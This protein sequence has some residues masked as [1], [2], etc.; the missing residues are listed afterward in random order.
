MNT[1]EVPF[2]SIDDGKIILNPWNE[3][4]S[5]VIGEVREEGAEVAIEYFVNRFSELE[6]KITELEQTIESTDNKGS[7]LQKVLHLKDSL[8][9]HDALG[10]YAALNERLVKWEVFLSDIIAK[11]R[12]RNTEIKHGLIAELREAVKIINWKESTEVVQDIKGRWIKV[13]NAVADEQ[14]TLDDTF[15]G[16]VQQYFDRKRAFQED[17]RRLEAKY[18]DEYRR[19]LRESRDIYRLE[20]KDRSERIRDLK[21]RWRENGNI[22]SFKYKNLLSKF[23]Y[24]LKQTQQRQFFNPSQDLENIEKEL[25]QI[26]QGAKAF[27]RERGEE[28]RRQLFAIKPRDPK[29]DQ[30]KRDCM[31]ILQMLTEMDFVQSQ[32]RKR[33]KNYDD[34]DVLEQNAHQVKLLKELIKRDEEELENYENNSGNF[35]S[36]DS[37]VNHMVDRKLAQQRNKIKL[38]QRLIAILGG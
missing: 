9:K 36:Q 10:D 33:V 2:G 27:D 19:I 24:N 14:Q 15:W 12:V 18:E 22:P 38:K 34:L 35:S 31:N 6:N 8:T 26:Q 32:C 11:N 13:G 37:N 28:M 7:Y 1:P 16:E 4:P 3:H 23:Q 5:R 21:D 17:K 25:I 30:K 20:G 29:T